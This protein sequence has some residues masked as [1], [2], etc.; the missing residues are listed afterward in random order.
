MLKIDC[1]TYV[2]Q[3]S[4]LR[5]MCFM[6][7]ILVYFSFYV[8]ITSRVEGLL[9]WKLVCKHHLLLYAIKEY[10]IYIQSLYFIIS[11]YRS[12]FYSFFTFHSSI[13]IYYVH[14]TIFFINMYSLEYIFVQKYLWVSR[15]Y[16]CVFPHLSLV[17][18]TRALGFCELLLYRLCVHILSILVSN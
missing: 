16:L 4:L 5:S 6:Y 11:M 8:F 10:F 13:Y 17:S 2:R 15:R 18:V 12:T 7:H 3:S 14:C 9:R 1:T